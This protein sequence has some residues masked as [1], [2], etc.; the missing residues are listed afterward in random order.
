[1]KH[2]QTFKL[3][4]GDIKVYD[5]KKPTMREILNKY[6]EHLKEQIFS[7]GVPLTKPKLDEILHNFLI[8]QDEKTKLR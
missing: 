5:S 8:D 4:N 3:S 7:K 1:M 6:N 2:T